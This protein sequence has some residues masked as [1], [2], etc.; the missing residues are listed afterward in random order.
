MGIIVNSTNNSLEYAGLIRNNI[1][2]F[3]SEI[4][5]MNHSVNRDIIMNINKNF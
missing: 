1:N 2:V 4:K 3:N 5:I